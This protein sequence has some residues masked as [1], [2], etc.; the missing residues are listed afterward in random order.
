M[1][2]EKTGAKASSTIKLICFALYRTKGSFGE[3]NLSV[4]PL[5][6]ASDARISNTGTIELLAS[7]VPF[8]SNT[9]LD[10]AP[11]A[12]FGML[13]LYGIRD[14]LEEMRYWSGKARELDAD[15]TYVEIE[16]A[17]GTIEVG[18]MDRDLLKATNGE[19]KFLNV[20][21]MKASLQTEILEMISGYARGDG[22][23]VNEEMSR[24]SQIANYPNYFDYVLIDDEVL[25]KLDIM[26]IPVADKPGMPNRMRQLAYVRAG[27]VIVTAQQSRT[28]ATIL[29][30]NWMTDKSIAEKL[31]SS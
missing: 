16:F 13:M 10:R 15:F 23:D 28:D 11:R 17:V 7:S 24:I 20:R 19:N 27:S 1:N 8:H 21:R 22:I 31:R 12:G 29:L 4:E 14:A 5:F 9:F 3:G 2:T 26:V 6:G 25:S 30:P 18:L